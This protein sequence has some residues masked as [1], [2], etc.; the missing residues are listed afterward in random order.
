M[1]M[2]CDRT[3]RHHIAVGDIVIA[4]TPPDTAMQPASIDLRLGFGHKHVL[5]NGYH[6]MDTPQITL[7]PNDCVLAVTLERLKV[8][9][10]MVARVEGKSTWG[11]RFLQ[12]HSTAG[13]IDPG[14]YGQIT[15]ELR[16]CGP[17][18]LIVQAGEPIAQISFA[19]L[20]ARCDRPYGSEELGSHYQGQ[21]GPTEPAL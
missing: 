2:L 8:P 20:D 21:L 18:T 5:V 12:V 17:Q 1:T 14:F 19:Y 9:D 4:P 15:L 11:R 13:F 16:N 10:S 3:I 6:A 7:Q